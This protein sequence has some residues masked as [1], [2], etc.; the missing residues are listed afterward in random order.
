MYVPDEETGGYLGMCPFIKCKEFQNLRI[1]FGLDE[2]IASP[3]EVFEVFFG[4]RSIWQVRF[5]ATGPTGHGSILFTNTAGEKIH[6][7]MNKLMGLRAEQKAK[8]DSD[9]NIQLGDVT[10]VNLNILEGG[11][12]R[13]VVPPELHATFDI[14]ITPTTNLEEF[15][16][17]LMTFVSLE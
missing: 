5:T 14:R 11:L 10:T 4:E 8:L 2:G 6:R 3:T 15:K 9:P 7:I 13:N 1:G 12:G 16:K 17:C